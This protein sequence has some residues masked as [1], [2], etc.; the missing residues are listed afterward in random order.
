MVEIALFALTLQGWALNIGGVTPPQILSL[1]LNGTL[2][3]RL[4]LVGG[5]PMAIAVPGELM[6]ADAENMLV[7][8]HPEAAR[9]SELQP[10]HG[11]TRLLSLAFQRLE[12]P[13]AFSGHGWTRGA[14][15]TTPPIRDLG[16]R[17]AW[18]FP[19]S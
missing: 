19:N 3:R 8:D 15:R 17:C 13:C 1:I 10:G 5:T 14:Q 9:P 4:Q 12:A 2:L 16:V 7:L 18:A 11:D 6:R